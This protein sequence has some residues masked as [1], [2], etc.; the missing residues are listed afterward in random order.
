MDDAE[1][2]ARRPRA[3]ARAGRAR[4]PSTTS[5]PATPRSSY[6]QR[7]PI[8]V[9]KIDRSFVAGLGEEAPA[10]AI[11][12][13]IV[14]MGHALGHPGRGRG[15]R[16]P[17]AGRPGRRARAATT[18]RASC[19]PAPA[20]PPTWSRTPSPRRLTSLGWSPLRRRG[21]VV[22]QR[23]AKPRTPVRF[24]SA[25]LAGCARAWRRP[26]SGTA[27]RLAPP[28]VLARPTHSLAS[29]VSASGSSANDA[30]RRAVDRRPCCLRRRWPH[31]SGGS[32][33]VRGPCRRSGRGTGSCSCRRRRRW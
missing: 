25:P 20:P 2:P 28:C 19:S 23:P 13:A 1:V 27:L 32:G 10:E 12:G 31:C 6:L 4:W 24:R 30:E 26:R 21:G 8:D 5:A 15:H 33:R 16:D 17:R 14:G 29:S 11:V 7:F 18:A 3:P 22:T 9:L